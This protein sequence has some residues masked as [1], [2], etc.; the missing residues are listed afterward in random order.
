[1]T[2]SRS[3]LSLL[4]VLVIVLASSTLGAQDAKTISSEASDFFET[5]I[6]PVLVAECYACHS[7]GEGKKPKAE[8][9]LDT[10]AGTETGGESGSLFNFEK[11]S[12]SLLI[13]ALT[14]SDPALAMPPKKKLADSVIAD[15]T[16]W[17]RLGAPDPRTASKP[18]I[19]GIDIEAGRKHWAFQPLLK[20]DVEKLASANEP[21]DSTTNPKTPIDRFILAALE[22]KQ[23]ARVAASDRITLFRRI[24]FDITGLPPTAEQS[25]KF[26]A[27]TSPHA[28]ENAIDRLLDSPHFGEKWAR[29]WFDIARFAESTGKTVNFAYPQA[30]RYRDYVIH[31]FNS[32]KPYDQFVM[33]QLAG[34]LMSSSSPAEIAERT[35]ATGFLA[36]GPK[37]LNERSGVK[38]ELDVV[39]EQ[40]D[41]TTRAF[42]GISVACARCHDHKFDP[43]SQA[44][45]Y[46]MAGIFRSTETCYGT[47]TFINA[48]RTSPLLPLPQDSGQPVALPKLSAAERER[49]ENQIQS[50]RDGMQRMTDGVQRFFATGTISLL[51][52]QLDAYE[53]D[54]TPKLLAMG[55]RDKKVGPEPP[56]R[57][58]RFGGPGGF[59]YD[60]TRRIGDSPIYNRGEADQPI[61][62]KIPRGTIRVMVEQQLAIP[63]DTSGRLQLAEWIAS[64]ENPLTAR[65]MVNRV[66]LQLF[67]RGLVPTPDDFGFAGQPPTH[68]ELLDHLALSFMKNGWSVKRLIKEI[69]L[70]ETYQLSSISTPQGMEIDPDNTLY[71]RM[72][73][74]R[75]DAELLR[76]AM[77][78]VSDQLTTS[79]PVGS[80]VARSG[81]G[82]ITGPRRGTN[83]VGASI[84]DPTNT[85]RSVYLP[86]VRDNLPEVLDIFDG[87]DPTLIT[88]FRTQ[89]TVPSQS[90]Y[91]LNNAFVLRASDRTAALI[92]KEPQ[93][94]DRIR[95]AYLKI[96]G[97]LPHE[98]EVA[99]SRQFV[100]RYFAKQPGGDIFSPDQ[101]FELWSAFCQALFA[102]AEFQFRR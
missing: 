74:R 92:M 91:L 102:S 101:E 45:Y 75:L 68:P 43:I 52:A 23:L 99:R 56:S 97:R 61:G 46:A 70:S 71:W 18:S 16:E 28:I 59:S 50:T 57:G 63:S 44:D 88:A 85:N 93:D 20:N 55:V 95:A 11:P 21:T 38:F 12:E 58:G 66:W 41:V 3:I 72:A 7:S 51:Q 36:L 86:I 15:F 73:P 77:L 19:K 6:R 64:E 78:A 84:N 24:S 49:L 87:A 14:H 89:T 13:Q 10:K 26:L 39:D 9:V 79:P 53:L 48:Q 82:P 67:G 37:T 22:K 47:V 35:I 5:K 27:D 42:L 94:A 90:L 81:E 30:W 33:E 8:L 25:A 65:V 32:D 80:S 34:D 60:A 100:S 17:I 69:M 31:A 54:G 76:D 4:A 96:L 40:I 1:M 83:S 2:H 29:H 62:E 98:D